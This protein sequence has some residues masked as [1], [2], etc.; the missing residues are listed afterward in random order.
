MIQF[1]LNLVVSSLWIWGFHC[2]F[3]PGFIGY[4]SVEKLFQYLIGHAKGRIIW[5]D[6]HK[7]YILKP[8]ISCPACMASVHGILMAIW[9]QMPIQQ[10]PVFLIALCGLNF[11]IIEV[12]YGEK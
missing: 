3:S 12:L 4:D 6:M 9:L 7:K 1:I 2:V 11:I 5:S 8:I 10:L